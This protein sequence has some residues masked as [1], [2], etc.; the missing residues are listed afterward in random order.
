MAF[1]GTTTLGVTQMQ[2]LFGIWGRENCL[3]DLFVGTFS[4][5]HRGQV[6]CGLATT[7]GERIEIRTHRGLVWPTF[8][9]DLKGLEGVGGIGVTSSIDRQ[10]ILRES[11][12]GEYVVGTDGYLTNSRELRTA[13]FGSGQ[14]FSTRE[15]VELIAGIVSQSLDFGDG[16]LE[17]VKAVAGRCSAVVLTNR[18]I[19]AFRDPAGFQPLM[20]G[21]N[22]QS[23][24][25]ASE[26]CAFGLLDHELVRDVGP[27]EVVLI[28]DDGVTTI[29][30]FKASHRFCSFEWIYFSDPDSII[31]GVS[32]AG[33]RQALGGFLAE[34]DEGLF[35]QKQTDQVV[36][37]AVLNSGKMYGDG[38][39]IVSGHKN[40]S[41]F[42]PVK[43]VLRTYN[44]PLEMRKRQKSRK[45]VP[46]KVN[47]DGR[48][49]VLND[50][51]IRAG[52]T[53][54][55]TVG[56]VRKCGAKEVHVRIGCPNS[57]RYCVYDRLPEEEENFIGAKMSEEEIRHRIGADTLLYGENEDRVA[58]AIGIDKSELCLECFKRGID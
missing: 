20:I 53:M 5:Q 19:Y 32:V 52:I 57:I 50:D 21:K 29:G 46:I 44:L 28:N 18:G 34:R 54:E 17:A 7:D 42:K 3:N 13:L 23:W 8:E 58:E 1:R 56:V 45:L 31:E 9:N 12:A 25:V 55:G 51:S 2:G 22:D 37:G 10:P 27:G 48:I 41:L 43:Y 4:M 15:D 26:S 49:V 6:Y 40:L 30:Q 16:V 38:Y 35:S 14:C 39:H 36:V 11:R 47:I 33:V 24:M